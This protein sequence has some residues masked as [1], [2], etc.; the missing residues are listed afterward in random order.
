MHKTNLE[1][2]RFVLAIVFRT[3]QMKTHVASGSLWYLHSFTT[4]FL[5]LNCH[6][7]R[8][9]IECTDWSS[10]GTKF[11]KPEATWRY[12]LFATVI[13]NLK[14]KQLSPP[15]TGFWPVWTETKKNLFHMFF[16]QTAFSAGFH[17]GNE[18][19]CKICHWTILGS[20]GWFKIS[21]QICPTVRPGLAVVVIMGEKSVHMPSLSNG[22]F[23]QQSHKT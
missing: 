6:L 15:L 10:Q 23:M 1:E 16:S 22:R 9:H 14:Q 5:R 21:T 12:L 4:C 7:H 3:V 11:S 13:W 18:K 20:V 8:S 2:T 19:N 17:W